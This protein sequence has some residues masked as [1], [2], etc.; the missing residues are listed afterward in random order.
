MVLLQVVPGA[1]GVIGLSSGVETPAVAMIFVPAVIPP[2]I[3]AV[4]AALILAVIPARILAL[5]P[6]VI[7][8]FVAGLIA[9]GIRPIALVP[10]LATRR[11]SRRA[12]IRPPLPRPRPQARQ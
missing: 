3:P 8:V 4:T 5:I 6:S 11:P 7:A 9:L 12:G 10:A 1:G 2:L